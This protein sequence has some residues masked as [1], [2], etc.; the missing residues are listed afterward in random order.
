MGTKRDNT[1]ER[2]A[3]LA[4]HLFD[5]QPADKDQSRFDDWD[6]EELRQ[7]RETAGRI[8]LFFELERFSADRDFST[9]QSKIHH[10]A[11]AGTF[12][13]RRTWMRVVAIVALALMV[14]SAVLWM[15]QSD[16]LQAR[17]ELAV[18]DNYGL[19]KVTLPDGSIV[20]LNYGSHLDYP[21]Q[22][23]GNTREVSLE[24]E[25]FFEVQR[26]PEKPFIIRAGR[27]N[28]QVLG[29]SFNVNTF[30]KTGE[31]SVVVQTGKVQVYANDVKSA[32]SDVILTPGERG[33]L[34]GN[35]PAFTKELNPD[36]NFLAWK[37]HS[38]IFDKTSLED[39]IQQLNN[40]Y[41]VQIATADPAMEQLLLT[42]R[43]DDRP[44]RFILEVIAMTHNLEVEQIDDASYLLKE[45]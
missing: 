22:F 41:R 38:F 35:A 33:V 34:S 39:V 8:D 10:E 20:T 25:A 44:V 11:K 23:E 12:G 42:A 28:I 15:N 30:P 3:A 13:L 36:P 29:T 37:T 24:G 9:L 21:D 43:F 2:W 31:V 16:R 17:E 14:G 26:N 27:A 40:V 18:A 19:T 7:V 6:E 32:D 1:S 4:K 5:H 45:K